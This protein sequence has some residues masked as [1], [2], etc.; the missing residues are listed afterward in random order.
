MTTATEVEVYV[1]LYR[2]T[3]TGW[4]AAHRL[5]MASELPRVESADYRQVGRG[6]ALANLTR[7][8]PSSRSRAARRG[9]RLPAGKHDNAML[10]VLGS[11]CCRRSG[12]RRE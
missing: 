6:D 12:R 1:A 8:F 4:G 10:T 5:D 11:L 2:Q 7:L 3:G 9:T